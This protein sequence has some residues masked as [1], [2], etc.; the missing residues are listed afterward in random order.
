[1]CT[2]NCFNLSNK[3]GYCYA[4]EEHVGSLSSEVF[5]HLQSKHF[6]SILEAETLRKSFSGVMAVDIKIGMVPSAT[7]TFIWP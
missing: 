7:P 4:W 5:A 1:M 3:D 2:F 6:E